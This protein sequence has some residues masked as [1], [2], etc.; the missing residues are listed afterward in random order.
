MLDL[1]C[2]DGGFADP[3]LARGLAYTG[4]DANEH[5]VRAARRR[6]GD[7]AR[8]EHGDLNDYR[9]AVPVAVTCVFRAIYYAR[10][11]RDFFRSAASYTTEKLVF[12]LNPRQYALAEVRRDLEAVGFDGL[13]IRPFFTPQT[14]AVRQPLRSALAWLEHSGPIAKLLLRRR[15]TYLCAAYRRA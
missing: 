10:D 6:L 13:D 4:V 8:V 2:G 14:R 1:A 11:R 12:D 5:M 3:L 9:P 7:R 15:F